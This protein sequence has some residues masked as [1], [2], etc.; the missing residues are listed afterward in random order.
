MKSSSC[1][2]NHAQLWFMFINHS[3]HCFQKEKCLVANFL[4]FFCLFFCL[5]LCGQNK[6]PQQKKCKWESIQFGSQF[7]GTVHHW[8]EVLLLGIKAVGPIEPIVTLCQEA[9]SS[10]SLCSVS[11]PL[12]SFSSGLK[13]KGWWWCWPL[14]YHLYF[15]KIS[16]TIPNIFFKL[17]D[18]LKFALFLN[19]T[20]QQYHIETMVD[21][22][23]YFTPHLRLSIIV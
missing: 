3:H 7:W 9:G 1:S 12:V 10:N 5:C 19:F 14:Q 6:I 23:I 21:I 17:K 13:P 2:H 15:W 11:F 20:Y 4:I 8:T 22:L 18:Y 16:L